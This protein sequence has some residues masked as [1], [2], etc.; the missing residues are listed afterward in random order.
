L[1]QQK[2]EEILRCPHLAVSDDTVARVERKIS[3]VAGK[4]D[5]GNPLDKLF[6]KNWKEGGSMAPG[7]FKKQMKEAFGIP[8][9]NTELNAAMQIFDIDGSGT[10][11]VTEFQTVFF[12]LQRAEQSRIMHQRDIAR[13]AQ[14]RTQAQC[15]KNRDVLRETLNACTLPPFTNDHQKSGLRKI[16]S[17]AAIFD[18]IKQKQ[19]G[20]LKAFEE[21]T[22]MSPQ[23][24]RQQLKTALCVHLTLEET[25]AV[26]A[27]FDSDGDGAIST[28]EFKST[29]FKLQRQ[30]QDKKRKH[31]QSLKIASLQEKDKSELLKQG[32]IRKQLEGRYKIWQPQGSV[33]A[34]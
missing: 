25:A 34:R 31:A 23:I 24:F 9:S 14:K 19:Y 15:S 5:T 30:A 11:D 10:I 12:K 32:T 8:L 16:K 28:V 7:V 18:A 22:S 27:Y 20:G 1:L 29:F 4:F 13:Q 3:K 33:T 2:K 6:M 17:A 26:V 21:A